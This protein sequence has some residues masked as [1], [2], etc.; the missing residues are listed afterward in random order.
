MVEA[1]RTDRVTVDELAASLSLTPQTI[2]KNL[3]QLCNE[4][5]LNRV[6]G[7]AVLAT[8]VD[9]VRYIERRRLAGAA[10]SA[11]GKAVAERVPE[12]ASLFINVS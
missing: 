4:G 7:G 3:N 1:E 8:T 2:R 11:I 5:H 10:K 12:R 6:H 9:N